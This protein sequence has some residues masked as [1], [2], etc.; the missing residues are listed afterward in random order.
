MQHS[1][2]K[3]SPIYLLPSVLTLGAMFCGFYAVIQSIN[4]NF[5]IAGFAV[6]IAMIFDSMDGRVARL[7]HTSS[8]FG[9]ELD[10]LADMVSFG[11]A[12][13]VIAFNW[14]LHSFGKIGWLFAFVYCACAGLR[15]ARFNTMV[16]IVDKKYF[17]GMPSPAAAA[18]VVGFI[19][20]CASYKL[21]G[22]FVTICGTTITI[23]AALSMVSNIKFYSFKEINFQHKGRFRVLLIILLISTL[24]LIYP[25]F[26]IYGFFLS[27]TL[28][29]YF[30]FI[31]RIGYNNQPHST[32]EDDIESIT[33]NIMNDEE[34]I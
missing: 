1:I 19:Y 24:L 33:N 16:G 25:E 20:L 31:F 15:L 12:P 28:I 18:L 26:V 27:Y 32:L 21:H 2:K 22:T 4:N 34:D 17:L 9:A 3:G 13:A 23:V 5:V 6:F 11:I 30:N 29:S 8:P 7:T 10:S 14:K